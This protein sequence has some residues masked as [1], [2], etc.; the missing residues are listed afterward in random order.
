MCLS[1]RR[2]RLELGDSLTRG[3]CGAS[4]PRRRDRAV[5][6]AGAVGGDRDQRGRRG[7]SRGRT[8]SR[9]R[10]HGVD[11]RGE[12]GAVGGGEAVEEVAVAGLGGRRRAGLEAS[13]A[14][15]ARRRRRR[16]CRRCRRARAGRRSR[17]GRGACRRGSRARRS[18]RWSTAAAASTSSWALEPGRLANG[19]GGVDLHD[20]VARDEANGVEVVDVQVAEDAA[21]GGDVLLGRRRRVVRRGAED[22]EAAELARS[23]ARE[24][25]GSRRRTA[26]GTRPARGSRRRGR[27]RSRRRAWPGR[28]RR[29]SRRT[30]GTPASA[31]SRS[32]GACAGGGRR[33]HERVDR[34]PR[35]PRPSRTR[36]PRA[37]RPRPRAR[38]GSAS[39]TARSS[40]SSVASVSRWNPPIRPTPTSPTLIAARSLRLRGRPFQTRPG[41]CPQD[42]SR[43]TRAQTDGVSR[44]LARGFA[45]DRLDGLLHLVALEATGADVRALLHAVHEQADALQVRVEPP[46]GRD[47]RVRAVVSEPGLLATD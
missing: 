20:L 34:L 8:G 36:S 19:A 14:A 7:R 43:K 38:S 33:D 1:F 22:E 12:L 26:A 11:E 10:A 30:P 3:G 23:T 5:L 27:A 4:R 28:A 32:S 46:L 15:C 37:R 13:G 42:T 41:D 40:P 47:H 31:A 44:R 16:R 18:P 24:P 35:A 17:A 29:A 2:G 9:R 25:R 39:A 45:R 6:G 21:R